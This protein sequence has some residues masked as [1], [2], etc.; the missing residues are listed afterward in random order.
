MKRAFL[1]LPF[2]LPL[3]GHTERPQPGTPE[4][5]SSYSSLS[6]RGG[7][8]VRPATPFPREWKASAVTL[9]AGVGLDIA[10]SWGHPE[11][12]RIARSSDGTLRR[13][14]AGMSA[15]IVAGTLAAQ[16]LVLRRLRPRHPVRRVFSVMNFSV[17]GW[18][19]GVAVRN[20]RTR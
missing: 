5:S 8:E 14:G 16:Y 1:I 20:W 10:S 17:G 11:R 4:V 9:A 7:P 12:T 18:R 6:S 2:L 15:G 3:V 13:K 19:S